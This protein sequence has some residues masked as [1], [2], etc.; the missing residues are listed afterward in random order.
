LVHEPL[1]AYYNDIPQWRY[2]QLPGVLTPESNKSAKVKTW[3]ITSRSELDELLKQESFANGK[4]LQFVEMQMPTLD[5]PVVL[6][7]FG[8]RTA[9]AGQ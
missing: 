4:G 1:D 5:A 8:K 2:H 6:K 3:R 9:K 7:D